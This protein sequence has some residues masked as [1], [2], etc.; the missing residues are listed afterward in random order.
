LA[1]IQKGFFTRKDHMV[2]SNDSHRTVFVISIWTEM[3]AGK[4]LTW[5]GSIRTIDG[6]RMN[7]STLASLNRILCELSGWQD[8][9]MDSIEDMRSE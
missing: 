1:N 3:M 5:R 7:Y 2:N 4:Q 8:S 9:P 6:Q